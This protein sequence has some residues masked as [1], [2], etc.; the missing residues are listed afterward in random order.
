MGLRESV[1]SLRV[2]SFANNGN[3]SSTHD[4]SGS[5]MGVGVNEEAPEG[6]LFT[7]LAE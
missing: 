2:R 4:A 5:M 3:R 7:L 1:A 6:F